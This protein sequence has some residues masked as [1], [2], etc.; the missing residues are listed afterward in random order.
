MMVSGQQAK[1]THRHCI[2]FQAII[3]EHCNKVSHLRAHDLDLDL[4]TNT[5]FSVC[6]A[7]TDTVT[8]DSCVIEV[9]F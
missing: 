4:E 7:G 9:T 5:P 8:S 1:L 6:V 2:A 3:T